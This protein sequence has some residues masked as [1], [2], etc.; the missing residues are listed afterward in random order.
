MPNRNETEVHVFLLMPVTVVSSMP[1]MDWVVLL[2]RQAGVPHVHGLLPDGIVPLP[3]P[4]DS[5]SQRRE[6]SSTGSSI[7]ADSSWFRV[8]SMQQVDQIV[9]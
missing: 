6:Q 9:C 8:A 7:V 4:N 2:T 1:S 5:T 3:A